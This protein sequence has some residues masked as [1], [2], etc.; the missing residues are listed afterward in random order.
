MLIGGEH[1]GSFSLVTPIKE[2]IA[3][4]KR[5]SKIAPETLELL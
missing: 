3:D 4:I 1:A 2:V 5:T